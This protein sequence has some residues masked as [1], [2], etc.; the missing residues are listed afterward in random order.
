MSWRSVALP[1]GSLDGKTP[2]MRR[3]HKESKMV[4]GLRVAVSVGRNF[5]RGSGYTGDTREKAQYWQIG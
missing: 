2:E 3:R 4:S 1:R 5:G